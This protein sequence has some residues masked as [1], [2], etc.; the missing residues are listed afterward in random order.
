I[1]F[2]EV[3]VR[4]HAGFDAMVSN[5]P[6]LGGARIWPTFGGSY[7]AWLKHLHPN[8]GGEAVDFVVSFFPLAHDPTTRAC[9][10]WLILVKHIAQGDTRAAG[11]KQIC[12]SGSKIFRAQ[13]RLKWPGYAAVLVSVIHVA[14]NTNRSVAI[15]DGEHVPGINSY[16]LPY[17]E[18][19]EPS[20]LRANKG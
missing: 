19:F 18:E 14:K 13:R 20:V 10:F 17:S 5:P 2:P 16:L 11:L 12:T 9:A 4:V 3:F 15:L 8:S 7:T 1:E 6:F